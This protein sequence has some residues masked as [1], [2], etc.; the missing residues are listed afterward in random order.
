MADKIKPLKIENPATG[1]TQTDPFPVETNPAQDYLAAK[2]LA[3]ENSDTRLLDLDGSGNFQFKD[4][5]ETAYMQLWKLRRAIY[6]IFDPSNT[7]LVSTDTESAIKELE[8][9]PF[10]GLGQATA[11]VVG[12]TVIFTQYDSLLD[13]SQTHI[14]TAVV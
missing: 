5:T 13:S 9:M 3:L 1:G 14:K 11:Y 10:V 8:D 4:A 12:T 6:E 2:G 7:T